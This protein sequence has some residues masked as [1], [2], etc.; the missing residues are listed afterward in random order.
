MSESDKKRKKV[1]IICSIVFVVLITCCGAW[2]LKPNPWDRYFHK[3]LSDPPRDFI[4][5]Q[6]NTIP[7]PSSDEVAIDLGSGV[8]HETYLL[9][10]KG[11]SVIA[12]DNQ[13]IAFDMMLKRPEIIP[14]K[15]HLKTYEVSFEKIEII[16]S[17]SK[18]TNR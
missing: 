4:V 5:A 11:Y 16:P 13:K 15:D 9:L 6:L 7:I 14:Y 8:G 3:K 17:K 2:L 10:Q 18:T 1:T 12:I